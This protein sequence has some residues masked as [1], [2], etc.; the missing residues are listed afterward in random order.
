MGPIGSRALGRVSLGGNRAA[1]STSRGGCG[2]GWE[3]AYWRS[4]AKA[5]GSMTERG[6]E[7]VLKAF[8]NR[9]PSPL[10]GGGIFGGRGAD[11][12]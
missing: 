10:R 9:N 2:R 6:R 8:G 12:P 5:P 4:I 1:G 3:P 7:G 11:E